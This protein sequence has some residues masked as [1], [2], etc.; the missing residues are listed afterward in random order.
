MTTNPQSVSIDEYVTHAREIMRDYNYDSLPVVDN[1]KVAGI[2]T[3]QDIINIT[4]TKS[5]VTVN[6]YVRSSIPMLT[7]DTGL[8]KAAFIIIHTD[9]GRVPVVDGSSKLVGLLSIKDIFKGLPELDLMDVPVSDLMTK[10]VVVCQPDDN[11]SKT[12]AN[13]IEFGLTGIPV[14]SM[15]QEVIGMITREDVMKKGYARIE[16]ESQGGKTSTTV[17]KI[18]STPAITV[19]DNDSIKKAAKIFIEHNIGRVP[20]VNNSILVG[21]V[22]RFDVIR[23]CKVLQGVSAK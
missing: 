18:M 21:I 15:K 10:K 7:P 4:S 6:G 3:L 19:N 14:V 8:P 17:Q 22:D 9:E 13:M 5:D 23:A 11:L 16:R 1:G 2:I 12:W 20:V